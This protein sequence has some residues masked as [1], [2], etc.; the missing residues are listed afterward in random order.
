MGNKGTWAQALP[1]VLHQ[2]EGVGLRPNP[3]LRL[4]RT[5]RSSPGYSP[6]PSPRGPGRKVGGCGR[7]RPVQNGPP[8]P[9]CLLGLEDQ[10]QLGFLF[11]EHG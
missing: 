4:G 3:E 5:M 6:D 1:Q 8:Q 7:M 11:P 10:T 9:L 2:E